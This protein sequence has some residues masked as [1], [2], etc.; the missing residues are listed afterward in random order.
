MTANTRVRGPRRVSRS[1]RVVA[2]GVS[3]HAGARTHMP[4]RFYTAGNLPGN[5]GGG[6]LQDAPEYKMISHL[7]FE[8][9]FSRFLYTFKL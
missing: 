8:T 3:Y 7:V 6:G 9:I 5:M 2:A 4:M 1:E